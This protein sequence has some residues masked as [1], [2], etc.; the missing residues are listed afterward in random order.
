MWPGNVKKNNKLIKNLLLLHFCKKCLRKR[1]TKG[2]YLAYSVHLLSFNIVLTGFDG[3][4]AE[5]PFTFLSPLFPLTAVITIKHALKPQDAQVWSEYG[6]G[7]FTVSRLRQTGGLRRH[8]N[9]DC[10]DGWS[11]YYAGALPWSQRGNAS[12][13]SLKGHKRDE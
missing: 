8:S 3:A 11:E 12:G 9:T 4:V 6:S 5:S 2:P 13:W 10:C 7:R 1:E